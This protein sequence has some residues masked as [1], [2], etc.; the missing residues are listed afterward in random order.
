[1]RS[2]SSLQ[3]AFVEFHARSWLVDNGFTLSQPRLRRLVAGVLGAPFW[4]AGRIVNRAK[5]DIL[6]ADVY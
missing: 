1:M 3:V 6:R 4:M 5:L 2:L